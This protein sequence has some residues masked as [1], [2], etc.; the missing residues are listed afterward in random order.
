MFQCVTGK[1][2]GVVCL[3]DQQGRYILVRKKLYL[4]KLH[5]QQ[6]SESKT[7]KENNKKELR[8]SKPLYDF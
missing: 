5:K 7:S 6:M 2:L 3:E 4:L 8:T 1:C